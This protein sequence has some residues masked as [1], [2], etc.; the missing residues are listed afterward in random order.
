[1]HE[2]IFTR[3]GTLARYRAAPLLADRERF[4]RHYAQQSYAHNTLRSIAWSLRVISESRVAERSSVLN[5]D[6]ESIARPYSRDIRQDLIHVAKQW[7][8]FMGHR[9][10]EPPL[11]GVFD[12]LLC[13]FEEFMRNEQGL[14]EATIL[15]RRGM[16]RPFLESLERV[17]HL[18][19]LKEVT[20]RHIDRYLTEKSEHGWSRAS[21]STLASTLRS[22]FHYAEAQCW[23]R[24]GLTVSIDSPRL[25][26]HENLP[27]GPDWTQVQRL[28]TSIHGDD[29]VSIRNRAVVMLLAIYGLRRSEVARLRLEDLDWENELI[30]ITRTKQHRVQQY[31]LTGAVGDALVEY[32]QYAR[33]R[34]RHREV[35]LALSAPRRV[36]SVNGIT[37]IVRSRLRAIGV[38]CAP[39][40]PHGLRHACAQ[41]LL[42]KGF[43]LK[44]IG[45]QLGH[46]RAASTS[47][48]AKVDLKGLQEVAD[49]SLGEL[50]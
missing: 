8:A 37:A 30:R 9:E 23:C 1:M 4:L 41:H 39:C 5:V 45:D 2:K 42:A 49:L 36:L 18:R 11:K 31:P 15:T 29:P 13:A 35:F 33:P 3:P 50:V 16:L 21:L 46:R 38:E 32:L 12:A 40:G 28:I 24:S 26:A 10:I 48:Y 27:R 20:V 19:S 14:S 17:R 43:S 7:F 34:C 47:Y 22:F 25:Y 44:Q 6:I